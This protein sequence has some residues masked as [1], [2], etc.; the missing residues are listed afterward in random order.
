MD[1]V[2]VVLAAPQG[3][4]GLWLLVQSYCLLWFVEIKTALDFLCWPG[5]AVSLRLLS[6][7]LTSNLVPDW[8]TPVCQQL[9]SRLCAVGPAS[10]FFSHGGGDLG[11]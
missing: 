4:L 2:P 6:F 1:G 9:A 11:C 10:C 7:I 8:G 5:G 3:G